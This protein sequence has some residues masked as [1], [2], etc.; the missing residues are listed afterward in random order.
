MESWYISGEITIYFTIS[1]VCLPSITG[2]LHRHR[3]SCIAVKMKKKSNPCVSWRMRNAQRCGRKVSCLCWL[4]HVVILLYLAPCTLFLWFHGSPPT[5][6]RFLVGTSA[7]FVAASGVLIAP[8][9]LLT[10]VLTNLNQEQARH[11]A[12]WKDSSKTG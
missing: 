1:T 7:E 2:W 3:L 4:N 12:G 5:Y 8:H 6:W 10:L 9:D 11:V